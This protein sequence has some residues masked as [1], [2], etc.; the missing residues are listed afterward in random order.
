MKLI[1]FL[2]NEYLNLLNKL[3]KINIDCAFCNSQNVDSFANIMKC[4]KCEIKELKYKDLD[5]YL[6]QLKKEWSI[7]NYCPDLFNVE[8]EKDK[9]TFIIYVY[10]TNGKNLKTITIDNKYIKDIEWLKSNESFDIPNI[11]INWFEENAISVKTYFGKGY[12]IAKEIIID[13]YTISKKLY[14]YGV[15]SG[16]TGIEY[17]D[18]MDYYRQ[19]MLISDPK[20]KSGV[21]KVFTKME[22]ELN[23]K[24]NEFELKNIELGKWS[25][26]K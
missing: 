22:Y 18:F 24:N 4:A 2:K 11:V 5:F 3:R 8:I 1:T 12:S 26:I 14:T 17:I 9:D 7:I 25:L 13:I 16:L 15:K 21:Y 20:I 10:D 23:N 19:K 6:S